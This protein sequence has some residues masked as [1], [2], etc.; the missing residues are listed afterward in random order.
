MKPSSDT[1]ALKCTEFQ[2]FANARLGRLDYTP[3]MG[4]RASCVA[5]RSD[6]A[7]EAGVRARR[8]VYPGQQAAEEIAAK[9]RDER[10]DLLVMST[11]G[12]SGA[13]RTLLG[14]VANRV[15][16]LV[17]IPVLLFRSER[18]LPGPEAN[19][20]RLLVALDG[21]DSAELSLRYAESLAR[22]FQA[23]ILLLAVFPRS[24]PGDPVRATL[25][26]INKK[27]SKLHDG[28]KIHYMDIGDKFLD[29]NGFIPQDVMSDALHPSTKGYEIWAQA[30]KD[31]LF[32][33]ME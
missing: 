22:V 8:L 29:E 4:R 23:K 7:A 13:A 31:K 17:Q 25:A 24:T 33:L 19:F 28:D 14:S 27:I 3:R 16:Q 18:A 20:R 9:A 10:I 6:Q 15:V 5:N 1:S 2:R 12:R 30:V 21:S 32:S 11:R 26:E